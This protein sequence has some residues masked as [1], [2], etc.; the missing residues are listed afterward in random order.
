VRQWFKLLAA[1][2]VRAVGVAAAVLL[3]V[4]RYRLPRSRLDVAALT[5]ENRFGGYA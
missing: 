3:A 5:C 2:Q 1:G 4:L